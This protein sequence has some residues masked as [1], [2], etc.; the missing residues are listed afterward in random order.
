MDLFEIA[1]EKIENEALDLGIN[2]DIE[3]YEDSSNLNKGIFLSKALNKLE[4]EQ[5]DLSKGE[6]DQ[7]VI[8]ARKILNDALEN[9]NTGSAFDRSAT[10]VQ[11][12]ENDRNQ[13]INR[14]NKI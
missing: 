7:N 9:V 2:L 6:R 8:N 14:I 4:T 1:I 13:K 10:R 3:G 5:K 11:L 12:I